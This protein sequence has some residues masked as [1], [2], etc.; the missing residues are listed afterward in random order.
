MIAFRFFFLD[1]GL[2]RVFFFFFSFPCSLFF[3]HLATPARARAR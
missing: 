2:F 1:L 3:L